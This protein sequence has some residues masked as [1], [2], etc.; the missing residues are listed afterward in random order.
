MGRG[1][2]GGGGGAL[3]KGVGRGTF[4]RGFEGVG[5]CP[6]LFGQNILVFYMTVSKIS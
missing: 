3:L 5:H 1:E 4:E 6:L 2:G